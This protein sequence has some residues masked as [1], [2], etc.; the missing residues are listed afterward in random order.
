MNKIQRSIDAVLSGKLQIEREPNYCLKAD[1][2]VIEDAND[3]RGGEWY[4]LM[5]ISKHLTPENRRR[6]PTVPWARS[7]EQAFIDQ[8]MTVPLS[9]ASAGDVVFSRLPSD[10]GHIGLLGIENGQLYVLE[11]AT[12]RRGRS[13]GGSLNWVPLPQWGGLTTVGRMP[14]DWVFDAAPPA[15]PVV[16]KPTSV[17]VSP[18]P[19]VLIENSGGG[20]DNVAGQRI[21]RGG[22][23]VNATDPGAVWIALRGGK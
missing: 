11:N 15:P 23:T 5:A 4:A 19:R 14:R 22:I 16:V 7:M 9:A 3:W 1:R 18:G 17:A 12:V 13:L 20:W 21:S 2:Q 6:S 10:F 8:K